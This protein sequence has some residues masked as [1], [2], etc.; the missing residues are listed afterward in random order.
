MSS[1]TEIKQA[2]AQVNGAEQAEGEGIGGWIW[3]ALKGDFNPDRSAGQ[4]GFDMAVSLIP[5]VDTI[6]D[7]RDLCANIK[8]YRKDPE[9]KFTMFLIALTVIGFFP[10]IGSIVKGVIKIIFAYVRKYLKNLDDITNIGKLTQA[11]SKAVDA[12]L[13]KIV[14]FLQ[15]NEVIKWATK[16]KVP[17]IF[18]FVAKELREIADKVNPTKLKD[19]FYTAANAIEKL[20]GRIHK[21][22][23]AKSAGQIEEVLDT[24]KKY[25]VKM[26]N[27][28]GQ[29]T[30]P[31]RTILNTTAKKLDDHAL[32]AS[33]RTVN[34]HWI[35][36]MG[37]SGTAVM[38]IKKP[39]KWA[40]KGRM[41]NPPYGDKAEK[42]ANEIAK[43]ADTYRRKTGKDYPYQKLDA[44]VVRA[45]KDGALQKASIAGPAKLYRVIDPTGQGG[46]QYWM[47]EKSFKA[48][49]SRDDWREKFAVSP[50][51]NQNGQYVVYEVPAGETLH[52]WRGTTASQKIDGTPYHLNGGGDQIVFT[53]QQ[54]TMVQARP[55]IDPETGEAMQRKGAPDTSIEFKDVTGESVYKPLREKINDPHIKGPHPTNWGFSEWT[56]DDVK[57]IIVA[58]KKTED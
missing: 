3:G 21:L 52:V 26:G 28:I 34:R 8:Q 13:P 50:S 49:K 29:F 12:A 17:N 43:D 33:S 31:I 35:S 4:I 25:K 10:E 46:G 6:C 27:G 1:T 41:S 37:T 7:V 40:K 15:H 20:L 47:D 48:L 23:P 22:V 18:A 53:P 16:E 44:D 30:Q 54:D 42:K 2:W 38:V 45:F 51:F 11:T 36:P 32:V 24:L 14:E 39:P 19:T 5:I 57:G 9:N 55:R 56:P 58:L